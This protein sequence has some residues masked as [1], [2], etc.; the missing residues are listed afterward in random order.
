LGYIEAFTAGVKKPTPVRIY[1]PKGEE[2]FGRFA[3]DIAVKALAFFE[4]SETLLY[5][6]IITSGVLT[7]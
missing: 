2:Q 5:F 4:E 1:A 7:Y 3:L 6:D